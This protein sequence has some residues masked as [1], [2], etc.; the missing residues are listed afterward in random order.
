MSRCESPRIHGHGLCQSPMKPID[1]VVVAASVKELSLAKT[2]CP[3]W[4]QKA[5]REA[6]RVQLGAEH[7]H[8]R[9]VRSAIFSAGFSERSE[10][11]TEPI[12]VSNMH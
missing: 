6:Y 12:S 1:S 9:F 7:N 11:E 3:I 10:A 8:Q 2:H 5:I 4:T